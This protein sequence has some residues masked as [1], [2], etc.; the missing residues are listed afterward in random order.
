[1]FFRWWYDSGTLGV[2]LRYADEFRFGGLKFETPPKSR[3]NRKLHK[4]RIISIYTLFSFS[5]G[6]KV[7][8]NKGNGTL[9]Q[10]SFRHTHTRKER[11]D[12]LEIR[13]E[14]GTR[15][16]REKEDR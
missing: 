1:M 6:F 8:R 10:E 3:T 9:N 12:R 2:L 5:L 7:H 11:N 13:E 15:E 16:Q 4:S 14:R